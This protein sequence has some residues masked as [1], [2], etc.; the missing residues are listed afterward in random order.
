MYIVNQMIL[1]LLIPLLHIFHDV[2]PTLS[3]VLSQGQEDI[4]IKLNKYII[5]RK[6]ILILAL[7]VPEGHG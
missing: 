7:L 2:K 1:G 3:F 6:Q 4:I 5:C